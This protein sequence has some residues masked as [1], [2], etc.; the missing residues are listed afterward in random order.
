MRRSRSIGLVLRDR[1]TDITEE[2]IPKIFNATLAI[3]LTLTALSSITLVT[4]LMSDSIPL[5]LFEDSLF[6]SW[7]IDFEALGYPTS[8]ATDRIKIGTA[9]VSFAM[10]GYAVMI[11][12]GHL[13]GT[14]VSKSNM[15]RRLLH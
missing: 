5:F 2:W 14:M 7:T 13:F 3:S 10:L 1:K 15:Q 4:F 9:W 8:E 6:R 11:L 12:G